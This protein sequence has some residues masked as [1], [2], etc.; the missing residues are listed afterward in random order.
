[1]IDVHTHLFNARYLPIEGAILSRV[2]HHNRGIDLPLRILRLVLRP[3]VYELARILRIATNLDDPDRI[4][5]PIPCPGGPVDPDELAYLAVKE[6]NLP[7]PEEIARVGRQVGVR[8][9]ARFGTDHPHYGNA[10]RSWGES[11]SAS[12]V[13]F[14]ERADEVLSAAN[15]SGMLPWIM[16]LLGR[17]S[18]LA[19]QLYCMWGSDMDHFVVHMMDMAPHYE[20]PCIPFEE[21]VER[22]GRLLEVYPKLIGFVAWSPLREDSLEII[23]GA[24][25]SGRFRGVKVYPPSGYRPTGNRRV[26]RGKAAKIDAANDA[27]FT[28]C[29]ERD[30]PLFAHCAPGD[31][32]YARGA[33]EYLAHP[34]HWKRALEA[35]PKLRLCLGHAGGE[36][37]WFEKDG[38]RHGTWRELVVRLCLEYPNVY[39]EFGPHDGDRK[40]E[41]I[42]RFQDRLAALAGAS[43]TA[44][45][46]RKICF[47]SDYHLLLRHPAAGEYATLFR[48][49][50]ADRRLSPY[51]DAFFDENARRWLKLA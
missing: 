23:R 16:T 15:S 51:R 46:L 30:V 22:V 21:Q 1:M 39:C 36:T 41:H 47:G 42:R 5:S 44:A 11:P 18:R 33:G 4:P 31:M 17:E 20:G 6:A 34:T 28:W 3:A 27:L 50:F 40:P 35:H 25:D 48:E 8:A 37:A 13:E 19:Q 14:G 26:P 2:R 32:E 45:F 24:I 29:V 9:A 43:S 12:E 38:H 10:F 49:F 7:P